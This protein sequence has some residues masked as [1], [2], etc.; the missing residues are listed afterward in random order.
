[1]NK[2]KE[3]LK[4]V[5][6]RDKLVEP[7]ALAMPKG[8]SDRDLQL[9]KSVGATY[10]TLLKSMQESTSVNYERSALYRELE[11][12]QTHWLMGAAVEIF[13][14]FATPY[15]PVQGKSIWC[16]ANEKKYQRTLEK[17]LDEQDL[18]EKI[19]DW[20]ATLAG[21][22]DL[23]MSING[24][25]GLGV[26]SF[27]DSFHPSAV[28]RID[29]DG[30]LLG[31]YRTPFD[32]GGMAAAASDSEAM[33]EAPWKYVHFRLLGGQMRRPG[34]SDPVGGIEHRTIYLMGS[35]PQQ[36]SVRYGTSLL[37]NGL[38]VYKR[39]RLAEDALLLARLTRG[40]QRYV[41]KIKVDPQNP[42]IGGALV[43]EYMN[44]LKHARAIN[45][46]TGEEHYENKSNPMCLT[47]DTSIRFCDGS[48]VTIKDLVENKDVYVGKSVWS[49]NNET[50]NIE[51]TKIVAAQKTRLNAELVR[52]HLD[53][54]KWVDCTPDHR[55]MLRDGSYKEA[56]DLQ[57]NES[58]M[59]F[60]SK[61]VALK[62]AG[63]YQNHKVVRVEFLQERQDTYDITVEK[64]H[65]FSLTNGIFVHNSSMEDLFIPVFGDSGDVTFDKIGGEPDIKWICLRGDTEVQLL[66]D[67]SIPIKEIVENKNEY[68]GKYV[69]SCGKDG[70]VVP[71]KIKDARI[72]KKD[73]SFVRVH[74]DNEKYFDVT[75]DHRCMLRDG[76]FLE[77]EQLVPGQSLMPL[78]TKRLN[79]DNQFCYEKVYNPK[80][81]GWV[82]THRL[83]ANTAL[84]IEKVQA[85]KKYSDEK[86]LVI[87]HKNFNK[88]D[89]DPS[90]LCWIGNDSHRS[91]HS[92][93]R[94]FGITPEER[95]TWV[96][97]N[98]ISKRPPIKHK[99]DCGCLLCLAQQGKY[100][101]FDVIKNVVCKHCGEDLGELS[102]AQ[103]A[104]HVKW[105]CSGRTRFVRGP[106]SEE[107]KQKC[108]ERS[109]DRI[110]VCL[111]SLKKE[112]FI[113]KEDANTFIG[114]GWSFGRLKA[115]E[116]AKR[117]M[118]KS[119]KGT[120]RIYS[121]QL[122]QEK[123]VLELKLSEFL[124]DGWSRG[125]LERAAQL[126]HKVVRIEHLNV[127]ED[128][129]DLTIDGEE[130]TFAVSAGVFV[131]NCDI[132]ELRN[133]LAC[134]LRV[135]LSL[136]G[137]YVQEASGQLGS[138]SIEQLD[139][140]F[141]RS[142]KRLQ[143]GIINGVRRLCQIHLAYLGMDPDPRLFDIQMGE[144]S[145]A[146]EKILKEALDTSTDIVRKFMD[147]V[148]NLDIT[149]DKIKL[150]EYL[151]KKVLKL[152][153]FD[154]KSF[155]KIVTPEL[156]GEGIIPEEGLSPELPIRPIETEAPEFNVP[157][158]EGEAPIVIDSIRKEFYSYLPMSKTIDSA[159]NNLNESA[160]NEQYGNKKVKINYVK[161]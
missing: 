114:K 130:H 107:D 134:S 50:H 157:E 111:S 18:E 27:D 102:N 85:K 12:S 7:S 137:G 16:N 121:E 91:Y 54:G 82:Y 96:H 143:R 32:T 20:A 66:N 138:D 9:L 49:I 161:G 100:K 23:M 122:Q 8:L 46:N 80:T 132:E 90:N 19:Y 42:E 79:A 118:S 41:Y 69:Y 53:N 142:S 5:F 6:R 158:T 65:N 151:N 25:P 13:A 106:L 126:N 75:P 110:W 52:V 104:N 21:F 26:V 28:S 120:I 156:K 159:L 31:F 140:R 125:K 128:A 146:E 37:F 78:Y 97:E 77:A 127:I 115:S 11:R 95:R 160:W 101:T 81:N 39:L 149:V 2:F 64:N 14:D 51:P 108:K 59:P 73:A 63:V 113:K 147:I 47:G 86:Y 148:D 92:E 152:N 109:K 30:V 117:R 60:Y 94:W 56:K 129:Y 40:I 88:Y 89:N 1:M 68:I 36:I 98:V 43:Q 71:R 87:H 116:T 131:H 112:K 99:K 105:N 62:Q 153:D 48:D 155:I 141:A 24:H 44:I 72:T 74:L 58:L 70:R 84:G 83:V 4:T 67:T 34:Y 45:T 17:F 103:Y 93:A 136:L 124:N 3:I 135:P 38:P 33:L 29:H 22:G 154:L 133:Q 55:F 61:I 76:S 35:Q 123:F 15:N 150:L 57:E 145:T 139:L 144:N 10:D 119:H